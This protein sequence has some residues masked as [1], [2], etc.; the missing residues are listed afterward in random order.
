MAI[1]ATQKKR[2]SPPVSN[3][4]LGKKALKSGLFSL[5]H[6]YTLKGSKAELNQV[7]STSSS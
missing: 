7:S 2:I 3:T 4:E 1:L 5:G 6:S